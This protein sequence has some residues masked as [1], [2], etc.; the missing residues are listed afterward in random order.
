VDI[1]RLLTRRVELRLG[2]E[3]WPLVFTHR[4]LLDIEDRLGVSILNGELDIVRL[5]A[6][7]LRTI[8]FV[9][10]SSSG[11]AYSATE[12][13]N[14]VGLHGLA[15]ARQ[16]VIEAW[17]AAMPA[18]DEADADDKEQAIVKARTWMEVWGNNR[19]YLHLT[20]DEWLDMTPRMCQSLDRARREEFRRIDLMVSRV[21]STIANYAGKQAAKPVSG[22]AFMLD[23][24]PRKKITPG[25]VEYWDRL[26][27]MG[28]SGRVN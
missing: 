6:K 12:I 17:V 27:G 28:G 15:V 23:P 1:T 5:S 2:D 26:L 10:L 16:S 3:R 21:S 11:A 22:D 19:Q 9:A 14:R 20:N 4:V 25:S 8:L 13:G 18:K 7:G 24:W